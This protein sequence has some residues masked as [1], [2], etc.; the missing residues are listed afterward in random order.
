MD[1]TSNSFKTATPVQD[2]RF[3]ANDLL[4]SDSSPLAPFHRRD[5][6]KATLW[7]RAP[8]LE[9]QAMAIAPSTIAQRLEA[10][11]IKH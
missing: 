8:R 6:W 11:A 2:L 4:C 1:G 5:L 9:L 7:P 3:R 10:E